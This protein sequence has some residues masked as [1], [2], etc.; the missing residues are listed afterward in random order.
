MKH[1]MRLHNVPFELIKKG[2]KNVELRLYDEKRRLLKVGDIIEFINRTTS[3]TIIVEVL[4]LCIY[5]SF[6]ELYKHFDKIAMGYS[7]DAIVDY[8]DMEI[9]YSKEEQENFGVVAIKIK[10]LNKESN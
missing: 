3:E 2:T 5:K 8:R 1:E 6:E 4:E 7:K 9:Y 10:L